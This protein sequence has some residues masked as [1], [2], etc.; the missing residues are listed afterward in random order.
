MLF[1]ERDAADAP[2][3]SVAA[4]PLQATYLRTV[5]VSGLGG[6]SGDHEVQAIAN[7]FSYSSFRIDVTGT[8]RCLVYGGPYKPPFGD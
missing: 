2:G 7:R 4:F 3:S 8:Q 5:S 6:D 1:E